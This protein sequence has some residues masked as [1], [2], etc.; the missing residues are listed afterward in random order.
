MGKNHERSDEGRAVPLIGKMI[1]ATDKRCDRERDEL[2][3]LRTISPSGALVDL[4]EE[5]S[6]FF[7]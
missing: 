1:G 6:E 4:C 7:Y 5:V 3:T 2:V